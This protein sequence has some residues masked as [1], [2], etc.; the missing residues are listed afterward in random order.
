MKTLIIDVSAGSF[1]HYVQQYGTTDGILY[2]CW[3]RV[4][5]PAMVAMV[6]VLFSLYV[7]HSLVT[8]GGTA[9]EI[10]DLVLYVSVV[11][12]MAGGLVSWMIV[13]GFYNWIRM[14]DREEAEEP[15]RVDEPVAGALWQPPPG[16]QLLWVKHDDSGRILTVAPWTARLQKSAQ[17]PQDPEFFIS[18]L[19]V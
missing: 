8:V 13:C 5:R 3:Y 4:A 16:V 19:A 14:R 18:A 12:S 2:G 7:Y 17:E 1:R 10:A 15:F 9:A 11:A 6:W